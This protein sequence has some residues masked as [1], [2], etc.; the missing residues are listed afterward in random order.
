MNPVSGPLLSIQSSSA[1]QL[2]SVNSNVT[3][4]SSDGGA[5]TDGAS[6]SSF[7]ASTWAA[8][9]SASVSR[10]TTV[11]DFVATGIASA[12]TTTT[13]ALGD[14]V[15]NTLNTA[16]TSN[17]HYNL[18]FAVRLAS[19]TFTDMDVYYSVDGTTHSISCVSGQAI[20]TSTWTKVNCSFTAPASGI[21][22]NNAIII[23]QNGTTAH[24]FYVD[25][26]SVTIAADYNYATDGGVD[27]DV[28][29]STNWSFV[30]G[31]GGAGSVA[32]N[33]SDGYDA[34]DSAGV[35]L[36]TGG[37]MPVYVTSFL[38]TLS[39]TRSIV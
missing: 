28:N 16:L 37:P 15:K 39:L 10:Y 17:M 19:G 21:T 38:S 30:S 29:F 35:T 25:N 32:R 12:Q 27:D 5:K 33:T 18:S 23:V 9:G 26:L 36:T 7:P 22:S 14:G 24:T 4:Y 34:S 8:V 11:G 13:T 3:E 1:A 6:S 31:S 2:L 20:L